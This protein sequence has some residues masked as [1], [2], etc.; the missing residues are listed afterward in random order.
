MVLPSLRALLPEP[1]LCPLPTAVGASLHESTPVS[2]CPRS[3]PSA[4]SVLGDPRAQPHAGLGVLDP[5]MH[6]LPRGPFLGSEVHGVQPASRTGAR[7]PTCSGAAVCPA[8][9][10]LHGGDSHSLAEA[11][12]LAGI[13]A[14]VLVSPLS[15]HRHRGPSGLSPSIPGFLQSFQHSD[16]QMSV[17][18]GR[19]DMQ[20]VNL[21]EYFPLL[22]NIRVI[23]R[24][25]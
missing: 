12:L 16:H 21:S 15:S 3:R 1:P 9:Q 18:C 23:R 10:R 6:Q 7:L 19:T 24:Y 22:S 25:E 2:C 5:G 13:L 8:L 11:V 4:V 17:F 14:S 20:S